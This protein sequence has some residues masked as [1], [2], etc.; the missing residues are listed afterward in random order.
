MKEV[1]NKIMTGFEW[2]T[3]CID[4]PWPKCCN[5]KMHV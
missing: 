2:A 4:L 3:E 5:K 1:V